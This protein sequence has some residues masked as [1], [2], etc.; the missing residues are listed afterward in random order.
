MKYLPISF[1]FVIFLSALFCTAQSMIGGKVIEKEQSWIKSIV[2]EHDRS[3]NSNNYI[4][5]C[6]GHHGN[7]WS[8]IS[9]DSSKICLYNGTTRKHIEYSDSCS[10]DTLSFIKDNIRTITWAFDTLTNVAEF[11]TPLKRDTYNPIYNELYII[12]DSRIIFSHNSAV[13]YI[14][15]DSASFNYKIQRLTYLMYWLASSS[16]RYYLPIP[17]DTL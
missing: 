8:L 6:T 13:Y 1:I 3:I 16:I 2:N 7:I 5:Y 12:R 9:L 17:C 15:M 14:G 10:F 4:F 11:L